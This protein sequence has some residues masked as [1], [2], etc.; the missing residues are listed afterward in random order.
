M[1]VTL[2]LNLLMLW[3]GQKWEWNEVLRNAV[4]G[5]DPTIA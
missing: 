4:H 2:A 1:D 5:P 3:Q